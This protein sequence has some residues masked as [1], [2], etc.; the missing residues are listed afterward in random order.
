MTLEQAFRQTPR[1]Y[2]MPPGV[3]EV[4]GVDAAQPIGF[5]QTISQP[6]VVRQMLEWLQVQPG[7]VVL[8][9]G[10]G[11]GWTT[12]LLSRLTGPGGQV[13]ATE[14]VPELL[15][16]GRENCAR[17]NLQ[18]VNFHPAGHT[19]GWS[20]QAPYDRILV[21]AATQDIPAALT[22]QLG[23][24]GRMVLPVHTDIIEVTKNT[25]DAIEQNA[26]P[27]FVFVPLV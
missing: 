9:V 2:F 21:S 27:G 11:S 22:N 20:R 23:P 14:I 13:H 17:L 26:H 4:S 3:Q 1:H 7:N 24:G 15:S 16:F 5:G 10:S 25:T 19:P 12:A 6:S 18:N 8:D